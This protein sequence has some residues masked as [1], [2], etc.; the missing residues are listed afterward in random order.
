[1]QTRCVRDKVGVWNRPVPEFAG[2]PPP[3]RGNRRRI[4]KTRTFCEGR[5]HGCARN[6]GCLASHGVTFYRLCLTGRIGVWSPRTHGCL[7]PSHR[8]SIRQRFQFLASNRKPT[9]SQNRIIAYPL[10]SF[11]GPLLEPHCAGF[12]QSATG[13]SRPC[14]RCSQCPAC[15]ASGMTIKR[16]SVISSRHN[17]ITDTL[18]WRMQTR[19]VH[20]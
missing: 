10:P 13:R 16:A 5:V 2:A 20:D 4:D 7:E 3:V 19:G 6:A 11:T 9:L 15:S 12:D 8:S 14:Y 1:M 18:R 17:G